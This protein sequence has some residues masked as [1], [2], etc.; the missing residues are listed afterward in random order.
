MQLLWVNLIMEN[1]GALALV[2]EPPTETETQEVL[3]YLVLFN[4]HFA[5]VFFDIC[6][7]T[8]LNIKHSVK[9]V[10]GSTPFPHMKTPQEHILVTKKFMISVFL[11]HI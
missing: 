8:Q 9:G 2:T 3:C 5:F 4:A 6:R 1:L 11:E 7:M 10:M